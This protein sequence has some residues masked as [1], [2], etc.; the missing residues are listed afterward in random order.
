MPGRCARDTGTFGR[1]RRAKGPCGQAS[2]PSGVPPV[3]TR[4][5]DDR[6]MALVGE[7]PVFLHPLPADRGIEVADS[8]ID[9]RQ[10]AVYDEAENRLHAEKAV[11]ALTMS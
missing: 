6:R 1:H 11:M 2:W 3:W 10:P 4:I 7:D 9:G 8:V 5:T